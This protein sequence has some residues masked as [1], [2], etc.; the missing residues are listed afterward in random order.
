MCTCA[1]MACTIARTAARPA[2]F[3]LPTT[4]PTEPTTIRLQ[5]DA[6]SRLA[7]AAGGVARFLADA[8]AL[9]SSAV[10]GLQAAVVA[11]CEE[12]FQNLRGERPCLYLSFTRY[13]DRIEVAL[14][15]S[16]ESAPAVGLDAIV[17]LATQV[18]SA[19]SGVWGGVDRIQY[20][21]QDGTAITR[22][23][24]YLGQPFPSP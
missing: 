3:P 18:G 23:T 24:K 17:G 19:L 21:S 10:A 7:A 2:T 16:G 12:A 13:A 14:A 20:E 22:L 9:E 5:I 8:T 11:A 4:V 6:D 15:H 1:R